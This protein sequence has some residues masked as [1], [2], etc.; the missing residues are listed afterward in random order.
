MIGPFTLPGIKMA[1]VNTAGFIMAGI[2]WRIFF[3]F[4][5]I[6]SLFFYGY[7]STKLSWS[8]VVFLFFS[9]FPGYFLIF[10]VFPG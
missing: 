2:I 8:N 7:I 10:L 1:G 4:E 6:I 5:H 3:R 9:W